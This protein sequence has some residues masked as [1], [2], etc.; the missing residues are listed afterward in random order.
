MPQE[1]DPTS[2]G[3]GEKRKLEKIPERP[4]APKPCPPKAPEI[5]RKTSQESENAKKTGEVKVAPVSLAVQESRVSQTEETVWIEEGAQVLGFGHFA[6]Y[7]YREVR[8]WICSGALTVSGILQ[9]CNAVDTKVMKFMD[10]VNRLQQAIDT[11][12]EAW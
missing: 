10:W 11:R 8:S 12:E 2:Q 4:S 9:G 7:T 5:L 1:S 6:N 3:S